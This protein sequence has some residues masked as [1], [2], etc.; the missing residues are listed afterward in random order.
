MDSNLLN[1][2]ELSNNGLR[3][4]DFESLYGKTNNELVDT[5]IDDK[6]NIAEINVDARSLTTGQ[7]QAITNM[8]H[9]KT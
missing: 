5:L 6:D 4:F 1:S 3:V 7:I 9:L 2:K 8:I